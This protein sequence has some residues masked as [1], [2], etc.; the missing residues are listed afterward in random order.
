MAE[1]SP[2]VQRRI[3]Q[4]PPSG[5]QDRPVAVLSPHTNRQIPPTPSKL[6]IGTV[7]DGVMSPCLELDSSESL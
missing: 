3:P 7:R 2:H 4:F 6:G 1:I 5:G